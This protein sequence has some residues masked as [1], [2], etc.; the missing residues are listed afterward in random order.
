MT[1]SDEVRFG[2]TRFLGA[3]LVEVSHA[4]PEKPENKSPRFRFGGINSSNVSSF[5]ARWWFS[6]YFLCVPWTLGRFD[7]IWRLH[8]F[9]LGWWKTT[10]PPVLGSQSTLGGA[11][12]WWRL[13]QVEL[14]ANVT[15][16][17]PWKMQNSYQCPQPTFLTTKGDRAYHQSPIVF[18]FVYCFLVGQGINSK[19]IG[20]SS[21]CLMFVFFQFFF[22]WEYDISTFETSFQISKH[23]SKRA[24]CW[25]NT[26]GPPGQKGAN[27]WS[28]DWGNLIPPHSR[29]S[30]WSWAGVI[31]ELPRKKRTKHPNIDDL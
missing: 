15:F 28:K 23:I 14:V 17:N 26:W 19:E 12:V 22:F 13:C 18:W 24:N 1:S 30:S 7:P 25:Q 9:Q 5:V 31:S 27:Q 16:Q 11:L 6:Q 21:R 8:I 10:G 29:L 4:S 20:V 3:Y 2:V